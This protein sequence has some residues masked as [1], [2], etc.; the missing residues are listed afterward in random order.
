MSSDETLQERLHRIDRSLAMLLEPPK[1]DPSV[2]W[3][4][5]VVS[6]G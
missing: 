4:R 3:H 2:L 5:N 6:L 1:S